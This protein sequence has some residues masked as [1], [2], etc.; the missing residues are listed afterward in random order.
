M[1]DNISIE[2]ARNNVE[3]ARAKDDRNQLIKALFDL[4]LIYRLSGDWKS[5]QPIAEERHQLS[6]EEGVL[7]DDLI[8]LA[9][10]MQQAGLYEKSLDVL[11][12][13]QADLARV[14]SA[15]VGLNLKFF[16]AVSMPL[17]SLE[18]WTDLVPVLREKIAITKRH[19]L[20]EYGDYWE[21]L[22]DMANIL[23]FKLGDLPAVIIERGE[24]WTHFV[25]VIRSG[26][27]LDFNAHTVHCQ[28][29][30][31]LALAYRETN[32]HSKAI[33]VYL[34]LIDYASQ[35]STISAEPED[36]AYV[37]ACL[38]DSYRV[39][40]DMESARFWAKPANEFLKDGKDVSFNDHLKILLKD[41]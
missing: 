14:K 28:N 17:Y 20:K 5:L 38:A 25:E 34:A 12:L 32:Q 18:R 33:A 40:G 3:A 9:F 10:T 11:K 13:F 2:E 1:S 8:D 29:S 19:N 39:I 6:M 41:I 16:A 24:L 30:T 23:Q 31:C 37:Y 4:G 21:T 15:A 26:K 22:S 36:L 27:K 35:S 7:S